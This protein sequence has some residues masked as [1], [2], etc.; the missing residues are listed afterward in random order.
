METTD[1]EESTYQSVSLR[2]HNTQFLSVLRKQNVSKTY[3]WSDL[4]G[5][6]CSPN[7]HKSLLN[8]HMRECIPGEE[9]HDISF[10]DYKPMECSQVYVN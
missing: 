4:T 1:S 2:A 10:F 7:T 6:C 9:M 8:W 3:T 5:F